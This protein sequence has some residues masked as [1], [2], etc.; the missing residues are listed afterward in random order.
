M[1]DQ[2]FILRYDSTGHGPR[3]DTYTVLKAIK[4]ILNE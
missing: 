1:I 2:D 4:P 3:H